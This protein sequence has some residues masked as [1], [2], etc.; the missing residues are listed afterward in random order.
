MTED[1]LRGMIERADVPGLRAALQT[2]AD[3]ANQTIHWYLNQHLESDP[4]HFICDCVSHSGVTDRAAG[5]MA[6]LLLES[7]AHIN[8]SPGRGSPLIAAASLGAPSV[9]KLLIAAGADLERTSVFESRALHWA[10]WTG[11]SA[12]VGLLVARGARIE[13]KDAQFFATPLFWAVHGYG[14]GG[15]QTKLDQ[16]GAAEILLQAGARLQTVN[17]QGLSALD[18]AASCGTQEMYELLKRYLL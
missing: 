11:L 5:E 13:V 8:G 1:A 4:L 15:P 3:L 6:Q 7:G 10:A 14:P 12:T 9:A 18:L 2:N 17:K 16:V